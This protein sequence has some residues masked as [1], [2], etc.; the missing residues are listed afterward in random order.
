MSERQPGRYDDIARQWLA[1][2]ERRRAH[3]IELCDSGRWKH[4][5]T[6]TEL[7][8]EMHKIV[9]VRDRWASIVGLLP[10]AGLL[11]EEHEPEVLAA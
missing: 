3:F 5:F 11:P 7:R 4:Y 6:E 1:L 8:D 2:A 9:L 10:D